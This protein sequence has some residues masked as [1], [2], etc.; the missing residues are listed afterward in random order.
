M[1]VC[2]RSKKPRIEKDFNGEFRVYL[3]QVPEKGKAN[4][5]MIRALAE[6]FQVSK[7]RVRIVSGFKSRKKLVE[8]ID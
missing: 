8:V 6:Y 1:V 2:P 5:E 4:Q 7:S 3:Q